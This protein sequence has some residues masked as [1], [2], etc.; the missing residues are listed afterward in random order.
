VRN[1]YLA[2][3]AAFPERFVVVDGSGDVQQTGLLVEEALCRRMQ[4]LG[5]AGLTEVKAGC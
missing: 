4:S 2:L 3:A 1:G 5:K